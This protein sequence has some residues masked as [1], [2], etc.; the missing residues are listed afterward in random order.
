[1][2]HDLLAHPHRH[3]PTS[4]SALRVKVW[5]ALKATHCATLR[6]GV[7]IL[8]AQA[9]TAAAFPALEA[10]IRDAGASAHLL[11]APARDAAQEA[12]FLALFDR[13]Q[14]MPSSCRP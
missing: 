11:Q 2:L 1:L 3:L 13:S 7:Y 9:G 5:R 4:P 8:P 14:A 12:A 10:T 6:E